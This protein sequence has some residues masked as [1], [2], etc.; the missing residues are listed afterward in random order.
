MSYL[1]KK[2]L[3]PVDIS[4]GWESDIWHRAISLPLNFV[5]DGSTPPLPATAVKMLYD[6][7]A[8]HGLFQVHDN[9]VRA[10]QTQNQ[11]QVCQD[12]C[13]E[14]FVRT[15]NETKYFN[16]EMNCGGTIL[17]YHINHCYSGDYTEVPPEDLEKIRRFHT[18]PAVVEPEIQEPTV[19]RLGFTIPI[20]FFVRYSGINPRLSGQV[21]HGNF[22]KCGDHTSHPHWLSWVPLSQHDF[23]L[24]DEFGEL[25]FE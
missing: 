20:D 6:D 9:Y 5:L 18:L 4:A 19:W 7:E 21:W 15:S 3:V 2:S 22:T 24:P 14:F 11:S 10:V 12:S 13:V 16:F 25:I 8:I 17:L 1:I 23:H